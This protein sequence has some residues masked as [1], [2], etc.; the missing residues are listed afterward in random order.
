MKSWSWALV[1]SLGWARASELE[2]MKHATK[3]QRADTAGQQHMGSGTPSRVVVR[4]R[5]VPGRL[6]QACRV[7][8][9]QQKSAWLLAEITELRM[10]VFIRDA[11]A[12]AAK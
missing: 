7:C 8:A 6:G 12:A 10:T 5:V 1:D 11:A 3:P 4:I 2:L 9:C